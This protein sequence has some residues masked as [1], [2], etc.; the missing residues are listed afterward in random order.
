MEPVRDVEV[1]LVQVPIA[2]PSHR[3][4]C[5]HEHSLTAF[6][7]ALEANRGELALSVTA[8]TMAKAKLVVRLGEG[9]LGVVD[10]CRVALT[11]TGSSLG[12]ST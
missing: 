4:A 1:V 6:T 8:S 5:V 10:T 3:G 11:G 12:G 2:V 7:F 9:H